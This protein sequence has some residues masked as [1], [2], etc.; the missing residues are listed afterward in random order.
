MADPQQPPP[1][2]S[3]PADDFE[4]MLAH[5]T[6]A[7]LNQWAARTFGGERYKVVVWLVK[8]MRRLRGD[9]AELQARKG[10]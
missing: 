7:E 2:A 6:E 10:R 1:P 4:R 9:V 3:G 8:E 5:S